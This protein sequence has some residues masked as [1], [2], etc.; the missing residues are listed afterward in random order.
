MGPGLTFASNRAPTFVNHW[1]DNR[2]QGQNLDFQRQ[3]QGQGHAQLV[4][5]HVEVKSRPCHLTDFI[6]AANTSVRLHKLQVFPWKARNCRWKCDRTCPGCSLIHLSRLLRSLRR[7]ARHFL[8]SSFSVTLMFFST[9]HSHDYNNDDNY[10]NNY[11]VSQL[12]RCQVFF[13]IF[14]NNIL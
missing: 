4:S 6:T 9:S 14:I 12:K 13:T 7:L 3:S 5:R 1:Q 8:S 11:T 10:Y 2:D